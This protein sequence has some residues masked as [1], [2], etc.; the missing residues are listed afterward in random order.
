MRYLSACNRGP[1]KRYYYCAIF[2]I[3]KILQ[4]LWEISLI[5][6]PYILEKKFTC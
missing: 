6:S 1:L 2:A 3:Q 4:I 5:S